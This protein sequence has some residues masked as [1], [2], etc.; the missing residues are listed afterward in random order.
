MRISMTQI[1]NQTWQLRSQA[2]QLR[3]VRSNLSRFQ[4]DL[5]AAWVG[6]EISMTNLAVDDYRERAR[7]IAD[8]LDAL[9]HEIH[10]VADS[11]RRE[12]ERNEQR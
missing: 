1:N 6:S 10:Q 2:S 3:E 7:R 12:D 11:I 9:S 4:M 5:N 8:T